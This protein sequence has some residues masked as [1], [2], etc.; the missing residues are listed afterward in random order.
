MPIILQEQQRGLV[1]PADVIQT[2]LE[3]LGGQEIA[4]MQGFRDAIT[5][6]VWNFHEEQVVGLSHQHLS[7]DRIPA[8]DGKDV[9]HVQG[10]KSNYS[11][12]IPHVVHSKQLHGSDV[13]HLLYDSMKLL[14]LVKE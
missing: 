13:N 10:H 4:E 6:R 14:T 2:N 9:G 12:A 1:C 3:R 7:G 11:T 5:L 8:R